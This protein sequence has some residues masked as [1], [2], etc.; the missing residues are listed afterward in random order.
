MIGDHHGQSAGQATL[1]VRAV[2]AILGTHTADLMLAAAQASAR[3]QRAQPPDIGGNLARQSALGA[4]P[5]W[6]DLSACSVAA[7]RRLTRKYSIGAEL[8]PGG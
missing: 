6:G 3:R 1:L 5:D 2:D 8:P 4:V 7:E